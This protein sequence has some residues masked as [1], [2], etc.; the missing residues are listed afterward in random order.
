MHQIPNIFGQLMY[1]DP[2]GKTSSLLPE[3]F[4]FTARAIYAGY[5]AWALL[6]PVCTH[7]GSMRFDAR[8]IG[9]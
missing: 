3:D 5:D 8:E 9:R 7:T 1:P 6:D 4:S 2:G